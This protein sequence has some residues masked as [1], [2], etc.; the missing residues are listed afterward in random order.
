[1]AD[2]EI[3]AMICD[4]AVDEVA[5]SL[6]VAGLAALGIDLE[7]AG[8][9]APALYDLLAEDEFQGDVEAAVASDGVEVSPVL[10]TL[11]SDHTPTTVD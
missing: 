4:E 7:A 11:L 10:L 2:G 3:W 1:V 5:V 8:E 6:T 9:A